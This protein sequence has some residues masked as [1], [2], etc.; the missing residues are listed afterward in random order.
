[1]TD[2]EKKSEILALQEKSEINTEEVSDA[3]INDLNND[4]KIDAKVLIP[5]IDRIGIFEWRR[6]TEW[7]IHKSIEKFNE[8]AKLA[9]SKNPK[10]RIDEY[11]KQM[12]IYKGN[13]KELSSIT[14]HIE[15]KMEELFNKFQYKSIKKLNKEREK[16][17]NDIMVSA[18]ALPNWS[19]SL[20]DIEKHMKEA[21]IT[22]ND[23]NKAYTQEITKIEKDI[24]LNKKEIEKAKM[25]LNGIDKIYKDG[26]TKIEKK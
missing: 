17:M 24:N 10:E 20:S 26:T 15:N 3:L 1:M 16:K 21:E 12:E 18:T 23:A 9:Y 19:M 2:L 25:I 8:I 4:M 11:K 13:L 22:M 7:L 5:M 14:S 6:I